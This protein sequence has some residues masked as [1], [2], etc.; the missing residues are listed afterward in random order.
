MTDIRQRIEQH[1]SELPA[2]EVK[3]LVLEWIRTSDKSFTDFERQF[4]DASRD[5]DAEYGELDESLSFMPLTEAEQ[6]Q[7]SREA[8]ADYQRTGQGIPQSQMQQWADSLGTPTEQPCP[9]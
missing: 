2:P 6:I 3:A 4:L 9:K 1:I 7:K 5:N 8:L